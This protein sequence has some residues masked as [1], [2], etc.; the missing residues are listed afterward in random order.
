MATYTRQQI[1][2][3]FSEVDKKSVGFNEISFTFPIFAQRPNQPESED[4]IVDFES[5]LKE[6]DDQERK[7]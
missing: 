4:I 1:L 7:K 3:R 2:E 6:L 5:I